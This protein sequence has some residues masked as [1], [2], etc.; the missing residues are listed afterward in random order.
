MAALHG[1]H[2]GTPCSLIASSF[3]TSSL[4]YPSDSVETYQSALL[5]RARGLPRSV[6]LNR[7]Q[8]I[9][10]RYNSK[11]AGYVIG[12]SPSKNIKNV[13]ELIDRFNPQNPGG[14]DLHQVVAN[15]KLMIIYAK[16]YLSGEWN[17]LPQMERNH[18]LDRLSER[19][20]DEIL[21]EELEN[22]LI[23]GR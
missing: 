10:D 9:I 1:S 12:L 17:V 21:F 5:V 4:R 6:L 14:S 16:E 13:Q 3:W 23:K 15:L 2:A 8:W 7:V 11:P 20:S 19:L 22:R 18:H